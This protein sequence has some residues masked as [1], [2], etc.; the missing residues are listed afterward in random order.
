MGATVGAGGNVWVSVQCMDLVG[1]DH[2][3]GWLAG[4]LQKEGNGVPKSSFEI[5]L[6]YILAELLRYEAGEFYVY[7]FIYHWMVIGS[8]SLSNPLLW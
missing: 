7:T 2:E 1:W 3:C 6:S 5:L 8:S 4:W